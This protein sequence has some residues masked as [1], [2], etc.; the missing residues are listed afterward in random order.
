[1]KTN[2]SKRAKK[3]KVANAIISVVMAIVCLILLIPFLW[4]VVSSFQPNADSLFSDPP[5][6]PSPWRFENYLDV[7]TTW[8]FGKMLGNTLIVVFGSM[9]LSIFAS[10]LVAYG[11]ARFR[12]RGKKVMFSVML[13]TMMLP[14]IV[15]L[16]PSYILF[17]QLGWTGTFLPLIVPAIGGGAFNIFLLRQYFMGIPKSIDEAGILDGCSRFGV[18]WRLIIPQ[19][20]PILATLVV[21]SFNGAWSDYVGPS[22]YL[23]G[24]EDKYTLSVGLTILKNQALGQGAI[25]WHLIMAGCVLFALPMVV[26]LFA[27]QDAFVRGIVTTGLKD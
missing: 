25:P 11:F 13:G 27:A 22:I 6:L 8:D 18:L 7:F 4:M 14:W 2:L 26:V 3:E 10:I 19:C 5:H 20:K 12:A 17:Q 16:M 24:A 15:T 9:A 1:M 23:M 21:F